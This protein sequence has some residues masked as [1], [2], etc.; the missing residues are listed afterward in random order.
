MLKIAICD[1]DNNICSQ[2]ERIILEYGK[3]NSYAIDVEIFCSGEE[4]ICYLK[5]SHSFDLIFLDIELNTTTGIKVGNKIRN[6]FD[7]HIIKIVFVTSKNGYEP[8]LFNMQPLNFLKKPINQIELIN[9]L[10]LT[11]KLLKIENK[12]FE[13]KIGYDLFKVNI[14]DILYFEKEGKK[15]KITTHSNT[16]YFYNTL[17]KIKHGLPNTFIETHNSYLIN[18]E[19]VVS[20]SKDYVIMV[21]GAKVPVSQR[22]LKNIRN[23]LISFER[24]K[25]N[26]QL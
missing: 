1:D 16:D 25:K 22:N 17:E 5:K 23:M 11:I 18:F 21:D 24:E 6:D 15:I 7:D 9:C 12:T 14:K 3:L 4:L 2:L 13:Y 20:S 10:N 26:A 8:Q 19:K